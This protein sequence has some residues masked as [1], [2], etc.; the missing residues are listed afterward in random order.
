[1]KI[2]IEKTRRICRDLLN[3]TQKE[4]DILKVA[5]ILGARIAT[6]TGEKTK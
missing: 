3:K 6:K 5:E 4:D 1:M 2:D